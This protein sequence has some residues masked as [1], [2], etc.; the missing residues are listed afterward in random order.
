MARNYL[1]KAT[2]TSETD[3][4]DVQATVHTILQDIEKGRDDA[5]MALVNRP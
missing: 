3:A 4:T 2:K 5:A 1:K